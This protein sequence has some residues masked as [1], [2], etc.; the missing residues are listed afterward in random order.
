MFY[1]K[2]NDFYKKMR[3]YLYNVL[4]LSATI[5]LFVGCE[6]SVVVSA[7]AFGSANASVNIS[8][9][10]LL[11]ADTSSGLI[12]KDA[13]TP[14]VT[15]YGSVVNTQSKLSESGVVVR[16]VGTDTP[17]GNTISREDG[18]WEITLPIVPDRNDENVTLFAIEIQKKGAVMSPISMYCKDPIVW[19]LLNV[20]DPNTYMVAGVYSKSLPWGNLYAKIDN[21]LYITM[22]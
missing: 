8:L 12:P 21:L 6:P 15:F 1:G 18:S 22:E 16:I 7:Y 17:G 5:T 20:E 2:R 10:Q 9:T 11:L 19:E 3:H 13:D 4:I 14:Q